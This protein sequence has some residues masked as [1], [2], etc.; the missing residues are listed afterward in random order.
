MDLGITTLISGVYDPRGE[1]ADGV[2]ESDYR[3]EVGIVEFPNSQPVSKITVA[4]EGT[5]SPIQMV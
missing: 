2:C 4:I 5:V 3:G 1:L